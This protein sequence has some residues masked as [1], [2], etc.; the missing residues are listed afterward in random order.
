VCLE[1]YEAKDVVRVLPACGHAFHA[2]CIDAWLRQHPTCPVC[3]ASLRAK[4]AGGGGNRAAPPPDYSALVAGAAARAAPSHHVP[5][6]S[7]S[8]DAAS[9][10]APDA[11]GRL[12]IIIEEPASSP[13]GPSPAAAGAGRHSPCAEAA[14]RQSASA[15]AGASSEHC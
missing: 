13:D 1:E 11:D 15:A 7:S 4:A 5:A 6:A 8:D 10:Q 12:E 3:R 9:P 14:A 2:P